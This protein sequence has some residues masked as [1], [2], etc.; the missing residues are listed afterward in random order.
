MHVHLPELA[1]EGGAGPIAV[2][3]PLLGF[4]PRYP[5]AVSE[6]LDAQFLRGEGQDVQ[7]PR[8]VTQDHLAPP[9]QHHY[10]PPITQIPDDRGHRPH[11]E[12]VAD[13][14][15]FP[16]QGHLCVGAA[17]HDLQAARAG[18]GVACGGGPFQEAAQDG[19]QTFA[20]AGASLVALG[21]D[22]DR[23]AEAPRGAHQQLLVDIVGSKERCCGPPDLAGA[24][25]DRPRHRHYRHV[26][27]STLS[28]TPSSHTPSR[29]A[30]SISRTAALSR[31][32][33]GSPFGYN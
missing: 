7:R 22:I 20:Q 6:A 30:T 18:Q 8:Q 32:R 14:R 19:G 29:G 15:L 12:G 33:R 26:C 3:D 23:D 31:G 10:V 2:L 1:V 11:I 25:R 28:T 13:L 9:S 27:S 16:L 17:Q 4:L 5:F 21:H 24:A